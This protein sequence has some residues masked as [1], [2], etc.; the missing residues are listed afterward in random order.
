MTWSFLS[1]VFSFTPKTAQRVPVPT[2]STTIL[3]AVVKG[4]FL[5]ERFLVYAE[6][7]GFEVVARRSGDNDFLG[8]RGNVRLIGENLHTVTADDEANTITV[9]GK[10]LKIYAEKDAKD[11]PWGKLGRCPQER[12]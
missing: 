11:L 2:G 3:T 12:R 9:D 5:V 6:D 10:V 8:A 7:N 1:S 4:I